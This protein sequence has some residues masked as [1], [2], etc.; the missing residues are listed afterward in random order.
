MGKIF[1]SHTEGVKLWSTKSSPKVLEKKMSFEYVFG[2]LKICTRCVRSPMRVPETKGKIPVRAVIT[3]CLI[4]YKCLKVQAINHH[5]NSTLTSH[6]HPH[7]F[8]PS[9]TEQGWCLNEKDWFH[10]RVS[11]RFKN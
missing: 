7:S 1:V 5:F 8:P 11:N 3:P 10:Q 4:D 9:T 2:N 6:H